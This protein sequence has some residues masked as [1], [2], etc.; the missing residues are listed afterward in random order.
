MN[1]NQTIKTCKNSFLTLSALLTFAISMPAQVFS[2]PRSSC[3]SAVIGTA[4]TNATLNK[5]NC[6]TA[7]VSLN[8]TAEFN[9]NVVIKIGSSFSS[10]LEI[11]NLIAEIPMEYQANTQSYTANIRD[12]LTENQ[13][14]FV[15]A[16][17]VITLGNNSSLSP[18]TEQV[19]GILQQ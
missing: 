2:L 18:L 8:T 5:I 17:Q 9:N 15:K 1:K 11:L 6:D 19:A 7:T 4:N 12:Y 16:F 13:T 3:R 14:L 10:N